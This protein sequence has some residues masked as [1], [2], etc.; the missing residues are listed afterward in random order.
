M[1]KGIIGHNG[2]FEFGVGP[3]EDVAFLLIVIVGEERTLGREWVALLH[4][5]LE[6]GSEVYGPSGEGSLDDDFREQLA[7]LSP[8]EF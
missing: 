8:I 3:Y 6:G 5:A 7:L 4:Y 1:K 2:G